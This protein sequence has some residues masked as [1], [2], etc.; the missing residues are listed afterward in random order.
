MEE[1]LFNALKGRM[2]M[3]R[4]ETFRRY[5]I[6]V[7]GVSTNAFPIAGESPPLDER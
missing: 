4:W 5:W 6:A 3:E 1:I 2:A 7:F